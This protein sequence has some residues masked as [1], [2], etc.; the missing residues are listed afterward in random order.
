[1]I[2][3]QVPQEAIDLI[4]RFEGFRAKKYYCVAGYPTI[5]WGHVLKK[6]QENL[7]EVTEAEAEDLLRHDVLLA[8]ASVCRLITVPLSDNQYS[9]LVDF[10]FN[11]GGGALQRSTLRAKCNREEHGDVPDEFRRWVYAGGRKL[12]GL[13]LRRNTEANLYATS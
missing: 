11:L 4:K 2:V 10:A 5:G 9:A 13:I 7:V 12:K 8:A 3:R 6:G 1:M